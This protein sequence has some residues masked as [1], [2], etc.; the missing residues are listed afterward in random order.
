MHSLKIKPMTSALLSFR[1]ELKA[2]WS[3]SESQDW[4]WVDKPSKSNPVVPLHLIHSFSGS[5]YLDPEFMISSQFYVM[6]VTT[7]NFLTDDEENIMNN[8]KK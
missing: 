1:N 5:S 8:I 3:H 6:H 2:N 7:L 4:F